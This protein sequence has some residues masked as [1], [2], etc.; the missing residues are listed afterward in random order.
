MMIAN[1]MSSKTN[2]QFGTRKL[3]PPPSSAV[4]SWI[5]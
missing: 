1:E 5:R 3:P 4:A 2:V